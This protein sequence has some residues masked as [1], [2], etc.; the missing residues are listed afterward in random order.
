M[1][2]EE[3][4]RRWA[5]SRVAE[6]GNKFATPTELEAIVREPMEWVDLLKGYDAFEVWQAAYY[7]EDVTMLQGQSS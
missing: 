6:V 2:T 3:M 4:I 5:K 7:W 1:T